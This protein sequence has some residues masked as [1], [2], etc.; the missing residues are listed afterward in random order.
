MRLLLIDGSNLIFRAYY[1]T[2]KLK[3]KDRDGNPVNAIHTLIS[4]INKIINKT[5]PTNIYIA[6]DTKEPTFRHILY[7]EYKGQRSETPD[8]LRQQFPMVKELYTAMGIK[9]GSMIGYEADDLI[10]TYAKIAQKKGYEVDILSGDKDL[11][12]LVDKHIKVITPAAGFAKEIC[13]DE[14]EFMNRYNFLPN[15]FIEY[16]AIVGDSSD[17]IIGVKGIG[18]KTACKMISEFDSLEQI[19]TYAKSG[20]DK[21]KVWTNL[22]ESLEIVSTNK[23]LVTLVEDIEVN[24]EISDFS[25]D[26]LATEKFVIYLQ[27]MGF[28]KYYTQFS[29][30]LPI[31]KVKNNYKVI[32]YNFNL[33]KSE[34]ETF[35]VPIYTNSNNFQE[36]AKIYLIKNNET[37]MKTNDIT[38]IREL[39]L[40]DTK[41]VVYNLKY[42]L[43]SINL[44]DYNNIQSDIFLVAC[45]LDKSNF[46]KGLDGLAFDNN[47]YK[48]P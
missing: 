47:V 3:I 8:E 31:K 10:A 4:M 37:F 33:I 42:I 13:Y 15:R 44:F 23:K 28:S 19:I 7:P 35:I 40:A 12:Q 29:N 11:L 14:A 26:T 2:E 39:I 38:L 24:N 34:Y 32:D 17:N 18:H 46:K 41:K 25:F 9:Y 6:L 1:A 22:A 20:V 43:S 21:K 30:Q 36:D 16:K 5:K 27:K 48:N 45:L